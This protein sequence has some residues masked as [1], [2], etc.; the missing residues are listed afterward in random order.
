MGTTKKSMDRTKIEMLTAM[1][2]RLQDEL[3]REKEASAAL[4]KANATALQSETR[5]LT[6]N[7]RLNKEL[8]AERAK[9]NRLERMFRGLRDAFVAA[10]EEDARRDPF[11]QAR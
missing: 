5:L 8:A 6:E 10:T 1:A 11:S 4:T 2:E 9:H 3:K 7:A